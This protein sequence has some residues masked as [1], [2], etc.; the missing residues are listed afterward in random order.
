MRTGSRALV[1]AAALAGI[2]ACSE[3]TTGSVPDVGVGP[4]RDASVADTGGGGAGNDGPGGN[5]PCSQAA[6]DVAPVESLFEPAWLPN[7]PL[8]G[9]TGVL[10]L[11]AS[12]LR[13]G[14]DGLELY[15]GICN[16]SE[17]PLCGAAIQ[18]EFYD[19]AD[20]L[21]GTASGAVQS[22][23]LYRFSQSPTPI[24]CVEPG[25]TAM[26]AVTALPD[27]L[28]LADLKSMG[29]RFPA[30][31]ID[32][33]VFLPGVS[34]SEL[35]AFDAPAGAVF[36]GT[37]TNASDS[38]IA[39]PVVSVFPVNEVGRPLGVAT[40]MASLEIPPGG[41]WS[42]ETS[43]VLNRGVDQLAYASGTFAP[44]P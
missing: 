18:I 32:D 3:R 11:F 29:H 42:F 26:A 41:T 23:R 9:V 4:E 14:A 44:S 27:G 21:I 1:T 43:V 16:H 10:T 5:D 15:A 28:A 13:D 7:V 8:D 34:V 25:Q 2:A 6:R 24:A 17:F 37:V 33:A 31:Q 38:A 35:Q 36:G 22:G 40:S 30:F 12:T 39:D 19:E 20:A